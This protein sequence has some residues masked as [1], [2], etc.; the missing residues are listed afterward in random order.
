M[1][2]P[3]CRLVTLGCKVNQ[4]ETQYVREMLEGA[5]Y[6]PAA[7]DR[8]ADLCVVNTCTV[9]AEGDAKGRQLVRRPGRRPPTARRHRRRYRQGQPR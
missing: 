2:P 3:T 5:G 1:S 8:P 9:T 4:Y 6:V 7:D